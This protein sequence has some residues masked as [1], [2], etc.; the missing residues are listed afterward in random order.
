MVRPA[1][2]AMRRWHTRQVSIP[3]EGGMLVV[4]GVEGQWPLRFAESV[5]RKIGDE[6]RGGGLPPPLI[7]KAH[8]LS[9]PG[10]GCGPCE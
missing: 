7:H 8:I 6:G 3:C 5:D 9:R 2:P 10:T 1:V 4:I